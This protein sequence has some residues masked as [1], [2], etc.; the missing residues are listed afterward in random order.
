MALLTIT[1]LKNYENASGSINPTTFAAWLKRVEERD[2]RPFLGDDLYYA[3]IN[4]GCE[5]GI[6][7]DLVDGKT[8]TN[9][10]GN[11]IYYFGLEPYIAYKILAIWASNGNIK[12]TNVGAREF[13]G[14]NYDRS[15]DNQILAKEYLSTAQQ[16]ANNIID[17][18]NDNSTTYELWN[19]TNKVDTDEF[20]FNII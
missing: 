5:S 18:L 11:N 16:Y 2:L 14:E 10:K 9:N 15:K 20:N 4:S 6:Y 12:L 19:C 7:K 17:F 8:Y 13:I 3:L 1:K